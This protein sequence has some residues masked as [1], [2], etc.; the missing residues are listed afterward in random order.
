[1]DW[2]KLF[3]ALPVLVDVG[4]LLIGIV[5]NGSLTLYLWRRREAPGSRYL[6]LYLLA[7]LEWAIA[8]VPPYFGAPL[9][10]WDALSMAGVFLMPLAW[11]GFALAYTGRAHLINLKNA[12]SLSAVPFLGYIGIW[13]VTFFPS[14]S[15]T[16]LGFV[17][18]MVPL[19][20]GLILLGIGAGLLLQAMLRYP[21]HRAQYLTL[22]FGML[23]PWFFVILQNFGLSPWPGINF[24]PLAFAL[25]A[26]LAVLGFAR[27]QVFDIIPV[28]QDVVMGN[29]RVGVLVLDPFNR[30]VDI[31][32]A[33]RRALNLTLE[34]CPVGTFVTQVLQPYPALLNLLQGEYSHGEVTLA[35]PQGTHSYEI[36]LS[37]LRDRH[38]VIVG[39]VLL[40]YDIT[41]R[42][43]VE[44]ELR[45]AR[46]AAESANRAKSAFLANMSHELRTPLNAI[47]GFAELMG[48]DAFLTAEQ[49]EYLDI[50]TRSGQHLLA[51]INDVLEMSKIEAGRTT[52]RPENFDLWALL[53]TLEEM[54]ALRAQEKGLQLF[55]ERAAD[56]PR[57]VSTDQSKLR[58]V[59]INLLSNAVKFTHKGG[60]TLRVGAY[61]QPDGTQR[62]AFEVEDTGVGIA[63]EELP[64]LFDPFVQTSS[65]E[66]A[67]EGTGLG[68]AISAQYVRLLGGELSV[69]ST[70]DVGTRFRFE[71]PVALVRAEDVEPLAKR[72]RV[73]GLVPGQPTYRLL[74]AEDRAANRILLERLLK[75]LGFEVRSVTNGQEVLAVWETW[76]PHLIWMDMRMPVMDGYEATRRIKATAQG[77]ATIIVAITAS[78]FEEDR[79][80]ILSEGCDDFVRKPFREE[81]I[82][83]VLTRHLGVQ[84]IYQDEE[85]TS[86][87]AAAPLTPEQRT[88]L[89]EDWRS[90]A[91]QAAAQAD[92][93][94]LLQLVEELRAAHPDLALALR[95]LLEDFRFDLI[96]D[97]L[98]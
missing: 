7:A 85:T 29:L 22:L 76:K 68:L 69:Q 98:A 45:Q 67:Q 21:G 87:I 72:R 19:T 65:G 92:A 10:A 32:P 6:I 41:E 83:D 31:N 57:Y 48:R 81:E 84:F 1:M 26:L 2:Q 53:Q 35:T 95:A 74:V 24:L 47:L 88:L 97:W 46:D 70:P 55:F 49:R 37:P 54:F 30:V 23:T 82:C 94:V 20:Y 90:R 42:K 93:D 73:V 91:R 15:Q 11:I 62:L 79:A 71:I 8:S 52:L 44:N 28:A 89:T 14:L 75:T 33:A 96:L 51:L 60:V 40:M 17:V 63:P 58:Q 27:Y 50:I 36:T 80:L 77:Q 5:L 9:G 61:P 18:Y 3:L 66:K 59:L 12:L 13:V 78:A 34:T 43:R 4:P 39:R 86:E 38:K 64:R 16:W 25:G 56:V